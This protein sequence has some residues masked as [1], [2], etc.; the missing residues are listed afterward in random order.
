MDG[1]ISVPIALIGFWI[2]P[3]L[4]ENTRAFF[5]NDRH[6]EIAKARMKRIGR[7]E[8]KGLGRS[9]WKRIF[10]RWHVYLLV[11]L[12]VVFINTVSIN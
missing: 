12:Y 4:P 10:G 5:F 1:V 2:Y 3:D 8:R 11:L 9:V 7:A 6:K